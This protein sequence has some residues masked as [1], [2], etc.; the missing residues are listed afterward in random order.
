MLQGWQQR[1]CL[2]ITSLHGKKSIWTHNMC[3]V[4]E[5]NRYLACSVINFTHL[6]WVVTLGQWWWPMMMTSLFCSFSKFFHPSSHGMWKDNLATM[7]TV[8][9][10][11]GVCLSMVINYS[12]IQTASCRNC[13]QLAMLYSHSQCL[14]TKF[15][16][17]AFN[18]LQWADI[19]LCLCVNMMP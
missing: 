9:V 12:D 14:S 7:E 5:K 19:K 4:L 3:F 2:Y 18:E 16:S 17:L 8:K 6:Q 13:V 11:E 1:E 10:Q 15:V